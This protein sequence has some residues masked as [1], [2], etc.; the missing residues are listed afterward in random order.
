MLC[1]VN[2]ERRLKFVQWPK[3][4]FV[5]LP[6]PLQSYSRRGAFVLE[7]WFAHYRL[8]LYA[9]LELSTGIFQG[10]CKARNRHQGLVMSSHVWRINTAYAPVL[11]L[12][13]LAGLALVVVSLKSVSSSWMTPAV[14]LSVTLRV[15]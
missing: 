11:A 2:T 4:Y 10:H 7:K 9:W 12:R 15:P 8:K 5:L 6:S 13:F 14:R 3:P 1:S